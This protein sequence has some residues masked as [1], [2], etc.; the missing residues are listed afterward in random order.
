M[1]DIAGNNDNINKV[2]DDHKYHVWHEDSMGNPFMIILDD[3]SDPF[4]IF[5]TDSNLGGFNIISSNTYL[6]MTGNIIY[7]VAQVVEEYC[8]NNEDVYN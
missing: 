4:I 3:E 5:I 1:Y 6:S 8:E 2:V 7:K